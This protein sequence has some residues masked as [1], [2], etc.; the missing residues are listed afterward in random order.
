[1][2]SVSKKD[3]EFRSVLTATSAGK[4]GV[5]RKHSRDTTVEM[6]VSGSMAVSDNLDKYYDH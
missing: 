5:G 1:M 3:D 2:H 4:V 6:D